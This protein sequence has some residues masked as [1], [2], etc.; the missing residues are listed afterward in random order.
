MNKS[1]ITS[2]CAIL[3]LAACSGPLDTKLS[4]MNEPAKA[5]AL[6]EAMT[7]EERG[8]LQQYVVK[9]TLNQTIDYKTA[10]KQA[11]SEQRKLNEK[12]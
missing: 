2:A 5:K 10:V 4:E 9:K 7:P 3:L 8:L 6:L 11:I 1:L 12:K